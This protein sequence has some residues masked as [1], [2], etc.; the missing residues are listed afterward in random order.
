MWAG[1]VAFPA[2]QL[3]EVVTQ[4]LLLEHSTLNYRSVLVLFG[5][6]WEIGR[7]MDLTDKHEFYTIYSCL[8]LSFSA[9]DHYNCLTSL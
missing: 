3:V 5:L 8:L 6:S 2:N 9:F 7:C 4:A 1:A